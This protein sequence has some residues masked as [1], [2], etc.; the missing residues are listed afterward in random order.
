[1]KVGNKF[2]KTKVKEFSFTRY[3]QK[4]NS[5]YDSVPLASRHMAI[6]RRQ[7]DF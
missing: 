4:A 5:N 3:K 7:K 6:D 1:M 2:L